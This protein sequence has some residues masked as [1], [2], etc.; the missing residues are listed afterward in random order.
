[1]PSQVP[2][3]DLWEHMERQGTEIIQ[4]MEYHL[5]P[6]CSHGNCKCPIGKEEAHF[7]QIITLRIHVQE[8]KQQSIR[9]IAKICH[10][11]VPSL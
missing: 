2:K 7:E 1:V 9:C 5:V 3:S 11:V 10:V 8:N 4:A 6:E